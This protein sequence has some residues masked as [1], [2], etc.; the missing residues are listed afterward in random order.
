M[1]LATFFKVLLRSWW[2]IAL[3]VVTTAGSAAY[4]VSKQSPIYSASATVLLKASPNL[5]PN[6]YIN[7]INA[8]SRHE[9][10]NSLARIAEGSSM[11]ERVAKTLNTQPAVIAGSELAAQVLPDT[12]LIVIRA[13]SPEPALAAA[14]A[15]AVAEE[16]R[17]EIPD[18]ALQIDVTDRASP[19]TTPVAP[20][21][22]RTITLGVLFGLVLGVV[23][24][25]LGYVLQSVRASRVEADDNS[26]EAVLGANGELAANS[27]KTQ[28]LFT[29]S[30]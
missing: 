28:Q 24:A 18:R 17:K 8:L 29:R 22:A 15:N 21:P 27:A 1:D 16:L 13:N 14:I 2:L 3:S 12:N 5:E 6:Q 26:T 10:I 7:A 11:R 25:L 30:S 9:T 23:F 19:S 4:V 20:Q